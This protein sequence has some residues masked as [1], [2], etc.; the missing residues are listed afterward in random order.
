MLS[1]A[2][3]AARRAFF[4]SAVRR[5]HGTDTFVVSIDLCRVQK[6]V[7]PSED[8]PGRIAESEVQRQEIVGVI[9]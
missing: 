7:S 1:A 5:L 3:A 8:C 9:D 6:P 4:L 2:E